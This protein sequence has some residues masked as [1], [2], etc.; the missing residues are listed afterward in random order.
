MN[1]LIGPADYLLV[2]G[3]E[4]CLKIRD[5]IP[6]R[7]IIIDAKASSKVYILDFQSI[8][9]E[10]CY[11]FIHSPALQGKDFFDTGDL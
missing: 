7:V 10:I 9:L 2:Y 3:T 1:Q 8:A 6:I 11:Q 5:W 4:P